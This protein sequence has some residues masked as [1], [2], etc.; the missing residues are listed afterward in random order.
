[1]FPQN[2]TF[3]D[4]R[5]ELEAG[6]AV[7]SSIRSGSNYSVRNLPP[8]PS[9]DALSPKSTSPSLIGLLSFLNERPRS[10]LS[11][12]EEISSTE[13][14]HGLNPS[15]KYV[16]NLS[17]ITIPGSSSSRREQHQ[18]T[19]PCQGLVTSF[20][21]TSSS[22]RL[23]E[24]PQHNPE[25]GTG[26]ISSNSHPESPVEVSIS[27]VESVNH[28]V[29]NQM[30][31]ASSSSSSMPI[32]YTIVLRTI[33]SAADNG[34]LKY[35]HLLIAPS[36]QAIA[37]R[38]LGT[39]HDLFSAGLSLSRGNGQSLYEGVYDPSQRRIPG[40]FRAK[41]HGRF[42]F[43]WPERGKVTPISMWNMP[44]HQQVETQDL[45]AV[46]G[47]VHIVNS[48]D[49]Y[50]DCRTVPQNDLALEGMR[51]LAIHRPGCKHYMN[52]GI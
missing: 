43:Q 16:S 32:D 17:E 22:T 20:D 34:S 29:A 9:L 42:G 10:P 1:M 39:D 6:T 8:D 2:T 13:E 33:K 14:R 21:S 27:S 51:W 50:M 15:S 25:T 3:N 36:G 7:T 37:I 28:Y 18:L 4:I 30:Y 11:T 45:G 24:I 46:R 49:F 44:V 48:M 38:I 26:S 23:G 12:V 19:I 47:I 52:K 40:M 31:P 5:A 35:P 41:L